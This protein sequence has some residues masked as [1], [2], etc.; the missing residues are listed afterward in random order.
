M[1]KSTNFFKFLSPT[2]LGIYVLLASIIWSAAYFYRRVPITDHNITVYGVAYK[3]VEADTADLS[4]TIERK[5]PN[6]AASLEQL[7][8]DEN[9]I[10]TYLAEKGFDNDSAFSGNY[11]TNPNYEYIEGRMS[12]VVKDYTSEV[13]IYITSSKVDDVFEAELNLNEF[14]VRNDI[15][16]AY[17][18]VNYIYSDL[19]KDKVEMIADATSNAEERAQALAEIRGNDIGHII[20]ADQGAFQINRQGVFEVTWDGNFDTSS[21]DKT[22]RATVS[23]TFDIR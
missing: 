10:K 16:L 1:N 8:A 20:N 3:D 6:R 22:I 15:N 9:K 21:I 5:N 19:E 17:W 2:N 4:I 7:F 18:D 11:S 14:A 23:V 12:D 13:T